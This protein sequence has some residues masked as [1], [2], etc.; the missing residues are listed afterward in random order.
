MR[1]GRVKNGSVFFGLTFDDYRS[2]CW[3]EKQNV[4]MKITVKMRSLD[5]SPGSA[6]AM[7]WADGKR[8]E[9]FKIDAVKMPVSFSSRAKLS[10]PAN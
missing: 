2:K 3:I 6:W 1:Q 4:E 10:K 8:P 5:I 9:S 7:A